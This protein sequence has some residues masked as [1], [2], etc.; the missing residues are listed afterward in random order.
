MHVWLTLEAKPMLIVR[1]PVENET[2]PTI[3]AEDERTQNRSF[4]TDTA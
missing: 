3:P 4:R 1:L 2:R